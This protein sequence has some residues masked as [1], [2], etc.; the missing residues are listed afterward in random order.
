MGRFLKMKSKRLHLSLLMFFQLCVVGTYV[1]ILSMYLKVYLG[2]SGIQTGIILSLASIPSIIIPFLS[3]WIVD[4]IITI[5]IKIF[6]FI[7]SLLM[8]MLLA[9][10]PLR[11]CPKTPICGVTL[12]PRHCGVRERH[13][14]QGV[15]CMA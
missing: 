6:F 9:K 12:I 11:G 7:L 13:K 3:A 5:G 1:P 4:R 15:R 2:F 8:I 14:A 10:W